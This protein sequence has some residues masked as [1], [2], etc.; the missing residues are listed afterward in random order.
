MFAPFGNAETFS[1]QQAEQ[2]A[3]L[4]TVYYGL[5]HREVAVNID[6]SVLLFDNGM[7]GGRHRLRS[8]CIRQLD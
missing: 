5:I 2:C 4:F 3:V 7:D 6:I 8:I 1:Q